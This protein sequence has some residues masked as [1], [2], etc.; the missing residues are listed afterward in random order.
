M[1]VCVRCGA[2]VDPQFDICWNCGTSREGV[3]SDDF[4]R[5]FDAGEKPA[6]FEPRLVDPPPRRRVDPNDPNVTTDGMIRELLLTQRAH[7]WRLDRIDFRVGCLFAFLIF[8]LVVAAIAFMIQ[9][10]SKA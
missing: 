9:L 10:M 5:E 7:E 6:A 2:E 3:P 1:W 8:Q 4:G